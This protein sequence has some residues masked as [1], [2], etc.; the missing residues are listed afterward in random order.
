MTPV[1]VAVSDLRESVRTVTVPMG[2]SAVASSGMAMPIQP[3]KSTMEIS[4]ISASVKRSPAS[5]SRSANWPSNQ[6]SIAIACS[7]P[8]SPMAG[9]WLI[10]LAV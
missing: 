8:A 9:I 10:N 2:R 1:L 6:R 7:F 3:A 4:A 5:Q